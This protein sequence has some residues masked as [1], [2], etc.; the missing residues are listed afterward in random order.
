MV[1]AIIV[2]LSIVEFL[3]GT[4]RGTLAIPL[5]PLLVAAVIWLIGRACRYVLARL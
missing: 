2:V 1:A 5:H 3:A 4:S